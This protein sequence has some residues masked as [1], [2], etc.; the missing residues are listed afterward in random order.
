M[1][2]RRVRR[3][4]RRRRDRADITLSTGHPAY[5]FTPG[6][7]HRADANA[8]IADTSQSAFAG[9]HSDIIKDEVS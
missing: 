8:I 1:G 3:I 7:F 9:A 6:T 2:R 4:P 5:P